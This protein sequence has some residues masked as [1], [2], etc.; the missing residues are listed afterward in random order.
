R[1]GALLRAQREPQARIDAHR[2]AARGVQR[3]KT[4]LAVALVAFGILPVDE[5]AQDRDA[6]EPPAQRHERLDL[7]FG[8]GEA[9]GAVEDADRAVHAVAFLVEQLDASPDRRAGFLA[10]VRV[11]GAAAQRERP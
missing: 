4:E 1:H 11:F 9:F 7:T 8:F 3:R 2:P 5:V 6:L 10:H